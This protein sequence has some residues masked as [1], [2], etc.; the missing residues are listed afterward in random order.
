MKIYLDACCLNR[1][2]DDQ[3]QSRIRLESEA[4]TLI[5]E[6]LYRREWEW[7]GSEILIFELNQTIDIERRIRLLL[8]AKQSHQTTRITEETISQAEKLELLGFESHDALHL[9]SAQQAGV[10]VFLTTDDNL[11]KT[12]ERLKASFSFIVANPLKWLEEVLK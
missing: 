11:R 9:A 5:L 8:L 7:V 3:R 2:F 6:K 12:A 10:D 4:I 1:P